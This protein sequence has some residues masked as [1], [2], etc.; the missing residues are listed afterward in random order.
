MD[1]YN[2]KMLKL[3]LVI[4]AAITVSNCNKE[5]S[6]DIGE[7]VTDVDGNVYKTL[8]IGDQ[9][10]MADNFKVL[11]FRNGNLIQT[12]TTPIEDIS[13][14]D[15]PN[16][17]WA[18]LGNES[19]ANKYGRLYSFNAIADT[20]SFCPGGWHIPSDEEWTVLTDF[21]GGES[22]A[23]QKLIKLGF[24]PQ[25]GGLRYSDSFS[26]L[27]SYGIYWSSTY[28][29]ENSEPGITLETQVYI[30]MLVNG[31]NHVNRSYRYFKSGASVRCIKD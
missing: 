17:Q 7:T 8:M 21:L 22:Q 23:Q 6:I 2:L 27:D 12:T 4:V 28:V 11:H 13:I 29:P 5:D 26:D 14:I 19:N 18:Y 9:I 30:R 16:F 3:F 24:A 25:F 10:W 31:T 20:R 1:K 15:S